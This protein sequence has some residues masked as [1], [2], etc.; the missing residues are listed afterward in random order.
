MNQ[1]E[2]NQQVI[3]RLKRNP[4]G[5]AMLFTSHYSCKALLDERLACVRISVGMPRWPLKYELVGHCKLLMPRRNMLKL[6]M[7]EYWEEY[8]KI[9]EG[10]GVEAIQEDLARLSVLANGRPL[11]LLCFEDLTK[12]DLWCH[13]RMFASWWEDKTTVFVPELEPP[14]ARQETLF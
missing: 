6:P 14:A 5:S 10:H 2:Y 4:K 9:L 3:E 1:D 11:V 7:D 8:A 13:R 12:P